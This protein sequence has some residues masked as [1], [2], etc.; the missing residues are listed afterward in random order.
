MLKALEI[1]AIHVNIIPR[2]IDFET[3]ILTDYLHKRGDIRHL[4]SALTLWLIKWLRLW[5]LFLKI[6][7]VVTSMLRSERMT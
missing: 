3:I 7:G 5:R 6:P 1:L 4:N 2:T